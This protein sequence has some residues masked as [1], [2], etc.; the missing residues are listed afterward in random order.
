MIQKTPQHPTIHAII[1]SSQGQTLNRSDG[2]SFGSLPSAELVFGSQS[3]PLEERS[4]STLLVRDHYEHV[5]GINLN[6]LGAS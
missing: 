6:G 3:L 4:S 5:N 1:E 2:F